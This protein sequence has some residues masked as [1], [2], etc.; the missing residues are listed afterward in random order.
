MNELEADDF[1]VL[2]TDIVRES[3]ESKILNEYLYHRELVRPNVSWKS[4]PKYAF[5]WSAMSAVFS[6][7][8]TFLLSPANND[9][10]VR[11]SYF[12]ARSFAILWAAS[13]VLL[14]LV[15]LK[16]IVLYMVKMYQKNASENRR[17][18]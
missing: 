17:R 2:D 6:L 14:V 3:E 15:N 8:E 9:A 1:L 16:R 12:D 13:F 18:S 4:I 11:G 7:V 5:L 10:A